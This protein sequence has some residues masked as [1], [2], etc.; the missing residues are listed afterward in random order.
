M[1]FDKYTDSIDNHVQIKIKHLKNQVNERAN[2]GLELMNLLDDPNATDI[3]NEIHRQAEEKLYNDLASHSNTYLLDSEII[4]IS[5]VL[6]AMMYYDGNFYDHVGFV[7]SSLYEKFSPQKIEGRIRTILNCR[8]SQDEIKSNSRIINTVLTNTIVPSA[9]LPLFFDFIYDIYKLN[10]EYSI[11][12]DKNELYEDF[13]FIY[14]SLRSNIL[15]DDDNIQINVTKK[16]YKLIKSTK[17]LIINSNDTDEI[18]RL[19]I[20]VAEIIDKKVWDNEVVVENPYLKSGYEKWASKIKEK[21]EKKKIRKSSDFQSRWEPR[22]TLINNEIYIVP[23]IHKVKGIYDY[24]DIYIILKNGDEEIYSNYSPDIREIIGGYRVT[25]SKIRLNNPIGEITYMLMSNQDVIYSSKNQLFRDCLVF[26]ENGNE[27]KNNTDYSGVA[28]FYMKDSDNNFYLNSK[29]VKIGDTISIGNVIFNFSS[30]LRP[31][32]VG[33]LYD[34]HFL[35]EE[36]TERQIPVYKQAKSLNFECESKYSRF[37]FIVNGQIKKQEEFK[38]TIIKS[39]TSSKVYVDIENMP[40]GIYMSEIYGWANGKRNKIFERHFAIDKELEAE[41]DKIDAESYLVYVS[42]SLM[43]ESIIKEIT[44]SDFNDN[45]LYI[46]RDDKKYNYF[47]PFEMDMY[48]IDGGQWM[49]FKNDI[50]IGDIRPDSVIEIYNFKYDA[51]S[52][53]TSTGMYIDETPKFETGTIYHRVK[54]GFLNS[55]KT[56]YDYISI[57]FLVNGIAKNALWCYNKCIIDANKTSIIYNANSNSLE[58]TPKFHG[59]GNV[60]FTITDDNREVYKSQFVKNNVTNQI[61]NLMSFVEYTITFYEKEKGLTL[62]KDKV[63]AT[64]KQTIYAREDFIGRAFKIKDVYFDQLIKGNFIRKKYSFNTTYLKFVKIINN[65]N[66]IGEIY[67]KS[68]SGVYM[69]DN[70]NPV[71]VEIC[72]DVIDGIIEL[73]VTKDGDGLLMDFEHHGIKNTMDDSAAIDIFSYSI[74]VHEE[75]NYE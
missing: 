12:D 68:F 65:D 36:G 66:F 38:Q 25:P 16:S 17:Q 35:I 49:S 53:L 32:I 75:K 48:R 26:D 14:D 62:K 20:R 42:S 69:L 10:L 2:I 50:W 23:P 44:I 63:L 67:K 71:E 64:Y 8:R 34:N 55:Y 61:E 11:S 43:S 27:I 40:S 29:I 13:K 24:R 54:V 18:I 41:V 28:T 56:N 58:I 46:T 52:M 72:S 59:K 22:Y 7:Y 51:I 4:F 57:L 37:D 3:I 1:L 45:W 9:F 47:I 31:G 73:S 74:A 15:L 30:L 39:A 5:L 60:F 70:I 33:E 19:S 21:R 6:I